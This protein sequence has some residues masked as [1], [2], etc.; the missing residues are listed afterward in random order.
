MWFSV[1][2]GDCQMIIKW[3]KM[4]DI[5]YHFTTYFT[6]YLYIIWYFVGLEEIFLHAEVNSTFASELDEHFTYWSKLDVDPDLANFSC[7]VRIGGRSKLRP[8]S[9]RA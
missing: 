6:T 7:D 3:E 5:S 2:T 4:A 1:E 8:T 9:G